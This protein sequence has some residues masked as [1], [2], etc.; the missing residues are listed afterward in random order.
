[1]IEISCPP[2]R[3]VG[4]GIQPRS[5]QLFFVAGH[6]LLTF[7]VERPALDVGMLIAKVKQR[8]QFEARVGYRHLN[9]IISGLVSCFWQEAVLVYVENAPDLVVAEVRVLLSSGIPFGNPLLFNGPLH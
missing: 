3:F 1:L 8:P 6:V 2:E 9:R 5:W 4:K 7:V